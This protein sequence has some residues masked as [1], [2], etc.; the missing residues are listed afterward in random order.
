MIRDQTDDGYFGVD[1]L[2]QR[3]KSAEKKFNSEWKLIFRNETLFLH[4]DRFRSFR[5]QTAS[6]ST[7]RLLITEN[8]HR[9][10]RKYNR[11][12]VQYLF[13]FSVRIL[14]LVFYSK[15]QIQCH[16]RKFSNT[17]F[18]YN[19]YANKNSYTNCT[20]QNFYSISKH[21]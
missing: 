15:V 13:V 20:F 21:K 16:L 4:G 9:V 14:E 1:I 2:E 10:N 19:N 5:T 17:L 3:I 6:R 18:S 7:K 11:F 8:S 12:K